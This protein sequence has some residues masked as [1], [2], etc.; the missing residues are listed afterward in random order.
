ML[1]YVNAI[2]NTGSAAIFD[3]A[4]TKHTQ[5]MNT[6]E[7]TATFASALNASKGTLNYAT[8]ERAAEMVDL[9]QYYIAEGMEAKAQRTFEDSG[10][11]PKLKKMIG[12]LANVK[13]C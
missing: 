10:F 2:D 13:I 11:G 8:A 1:K 3:P 6:Q 7:L 12:E 4:T 9:L 5:A